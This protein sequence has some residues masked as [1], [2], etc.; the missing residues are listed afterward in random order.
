MNIDKLKK[1]VA[2][3]AIKY[4]NPGS[5]IGIGTG[6]TISYFIEALGAMKNLISGAVSSSRVSTLYLKKIGIP[7]YN[8]C[9]IN[10][11][12]L[13]IDSADEINSELQMIKGKGAALTQE[14]IIAATA[15]TFICIVDESK[16]VDILG[17]VPLPVE[18]IPMA[19]SYIYKQI[20]QIGG[21]PKFRN[22]VITDNGNI[23]VDIFN[24][25][26]KNPV[27][28]ENKINSFPGVVSVG[29]FANRKADIVLI[30]KY[31]G[32][33]QVIS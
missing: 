12:M 26:I 4:I 17:N 6:T 21:I 29:I 5:I 31:S 1:L 14:K 18:I 33:I 22:N 28:L 10:S 19:K 13:Y 27:S 9:E 15:K 11:L 32:N 30:S 25:K 20:I 7:V 2:K 24:L 16:K 8:L 3:E 23:I